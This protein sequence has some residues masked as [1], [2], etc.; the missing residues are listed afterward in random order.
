MFISLLIIG[1]QLFIKIE[2][3]PFLETEL[4]KMLLGEKRTD[5][6]EKCLAFLDTRVEL[7][8]KGFKEDIFEH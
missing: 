8:Q 2:G 4:E 7:D 5:V 3:I 6:F 1:R